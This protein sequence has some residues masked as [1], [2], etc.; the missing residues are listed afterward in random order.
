MKNSVESLKGHRIHLSHLSEFPFGEKVLLA[1]G[2][3]LLQAWAQQPKIS[4][5][6]TDNVLSFLG[7]DGTHCLEVYTTICNLVCSSCS[8]MVH[9]D[10]TLHSVLLY[11]EK[12]YNFAS[13]NMCRAILHKNTMC[14]ITVFIYFANCCIPFP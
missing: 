13:L 8:L 3:R 10:Y 2:S 7:K 5:N 14:K 6:N 12:L 1:A 9:G 4:K 11:G